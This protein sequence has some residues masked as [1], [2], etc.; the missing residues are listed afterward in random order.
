MV[1]LDYNTT[2]FHQ[3]EQASVH[4]LIHRERRKSNIEK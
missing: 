1:R 3:L 4:L 2:L